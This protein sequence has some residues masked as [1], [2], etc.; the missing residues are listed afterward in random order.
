MLGLT[1]RVPHESDFGSRLRSPAVAARVG[2]WLGICF[3]VAFLTGVYSHLA[4][5]AYPWFAVPTQ[6][7]WTYRVTQGVHV[8]A[9]TEAVPLLLV[10][11][12]AVFPKFFARPPWRR[13][14]ALLL[15]GLERVSIGVLVAAAIFQLASGLANVSHWYPW[16]FSFVATHYAVAWIAVGA[17]LVHVAVKLPVITAALGR[18]VEDTRLDRSVPVADSAGLS[19]R[20]L[21]QVTVA[22]AALAVV[23]TAGSTV[24]ALRRISVFGVRSGR[25]PQGIPINRSAAAAGVQ[26]SALAADFALTVVHGD[27]QVRLTSA[28]LTALPQHTAVLPIAC[29]EGWSATGQWTGVR[30]QDLVDLVDAPPGSAVL[31]RSL[32]ERGAYRG[33]RLP[34]NFVA[35][36]ETLLA[37]ALGGEPLSIDHGYPCRIIAPNRPGVLQTK[38][39]SMLE[40]EQ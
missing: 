24:P 13:R 33:S 15:H 30:V 31:V 25:G 35:D 36:G 10:K 9:G 40:V 4:Q 38:W 34:A 28:Q 18:D 26:V 20:G 17:L 22:A 7:S 3:L 2:L 32:Q 37:L 16:A 27:R 21:L 1:A 19:R 5:A 29:V 39:V 12:W 23:S 6:P 8:A 14:R 11:L